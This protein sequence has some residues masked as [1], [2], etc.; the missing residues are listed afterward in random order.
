MQ[1]SNHSTIQP[2][3]L[4]GL[5]N[6]GRSYAANRHNFGFLALDEIAKALKA[7][8]FKEKFGGQFA[9]SKNLYLFKPLGFMN[10][11]GTAAGKIAA[12]YKI[13][14]DNIYVFHDE[15]DLELGK[16]KIKQGGGDGGHNGIK[17]LDAHLG[18]SYWRVRLGIG[19]PGHKDLVHD[20]VLSDFSKA[21]EIIAKKTIKIIAGNIETL[22]QGDR[23]LF[24]TKYFENIQ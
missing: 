8:E 23:N 12:F 13:P 5:G 22:V 1:P 16:I 2:L 10:N 15:L 18:K 19:H 4:I 14:L 17:S 6:P 7:P 21:E 3:L 20:H 9:K 11:S 24:L